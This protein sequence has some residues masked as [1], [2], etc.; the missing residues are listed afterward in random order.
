MTI[1]PEKSETGADERGADDCELGG[2]RIKWDLQIFRDAIIAARIS[3]KGVGKCN[4]DRA[5]GGKSIQSVSQIYRVRRAGDHDHEK[6]NR[7]PGA[8][9]RDDRGFKERHPKRARLHF[10]QRAIE[11]HRGDDDRERD[12]KN[13]FQPAADAVGFLFRDLEIV[14]SESKGAEIKHRK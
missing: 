4:G 13:K 5:A 9:I 12:L 7:E 10:D 6:H 14:V 8:H 2:E 11:K 3:Q 1:K